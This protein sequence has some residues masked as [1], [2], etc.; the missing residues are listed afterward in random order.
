MTII[1]GIQMVMVFKQ[2]EEG[3]TT[4]EISNLFKLNL[5]KVLIRL[6]DEFWKFFLNFLQIGKV[7]KAKLNELIR[8]VDFFSLVDNIKSF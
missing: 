1:M 8:V 5:N 2:I 6:K 7:F 4:L 3:I